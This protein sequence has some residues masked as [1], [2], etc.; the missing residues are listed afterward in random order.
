V[1]SW[2]YEGEL[3]RIPKRARGRLA[4]AAPSVSPMV[5]LELSFLFQVGR[6]TEPASAPLRSLR[7]SIGL[8]IAD[9]SFAEVT[10]AAI[11]LTWTRDPFD[12]LIAAHAVVAGVP[13]LTADRTILE[14][15]SLATWD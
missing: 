11:D 3:S 1:V 13:L 6:V 7:R 5:E 9:V 15:L 4:E 14:N 2:L 12:R 8:E 10:A